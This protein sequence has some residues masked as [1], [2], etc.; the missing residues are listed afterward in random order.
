L[1]INKGNNMA[2]H[3]RVR[4]NHVVVISNQLID[5]C[6]SLGIVEKRV[7]WLLLSRIPAN[8]ERNEG[9]APITA[10]SWLTISVEDYSRLAEITI[11]KAYEQVKEAAESLNDRVITLKGIDTPRGTIRLHWL[12]ECKFVPETYTV[13][14][15]I[16]PSMLPYLTDLKEKFAQLELDDAFG[17]TSRHSWKLFDFFYKYKGTPCRAVELSIEEIHALLDI[18]EGDS[19]CLYKNLKGKILLPSFR[20]L[21]DKYLCHVTM[22]ELKIG[23]RVIAIKFNFILDTKQIIV[24]NTRSR[25]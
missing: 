23:K 10:E 17:I 25:G 1:I 16:S 3:L 2:K 15:L 18:D 22:E 14:G 20:E 9:V 11:S 5:S 7:L 19:Y 24:A 8:V 6:Y 13:K 21:S 4:E 12:S